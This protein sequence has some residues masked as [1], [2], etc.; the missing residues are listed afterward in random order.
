MI[1]YIDIAQSG[2][3]Y[4]SHHK[5]ILLTEIKTILR[6]RCEHLYAHQLDNLSE[7]DKFPGI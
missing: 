2:F 4:M 3:Q 7:M 6:E 1:L 5:L